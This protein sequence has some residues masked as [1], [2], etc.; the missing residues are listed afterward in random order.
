[1]IWN[2]LHHVKIIN[3]LLGKIRRFYLCNF[4]RNYVIQQMMLRHGECKQC[5]KCCYFLLKCPFLRFQDGKTYCVIYHRK[6]PKQCV[7]FPID[8]RDLADV[9]F[10]CAQVFRQN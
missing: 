2:K 1:M 9:G 6:R 8:E 7:A 5:G 3:H 10:T 4:D